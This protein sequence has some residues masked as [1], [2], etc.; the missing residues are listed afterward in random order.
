MKFYSLFVIN[1]YYALPWILH[2][3][4]N[5]Y[6]WPI[7]KKIECICDICYRYNYNNDTENTEI[8]T[9]LYT[10]YYNENYYNENYYNE[11]YYNEN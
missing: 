6:I 7:D 4:N 2:Y 11:N 3:T 10:N 9:T 1:K 8:D 5:L